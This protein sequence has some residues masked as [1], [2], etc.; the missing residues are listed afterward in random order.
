[1]EEEI[2]LEEEVIEEQPPR[3]VG[4][5]YLKFRDQEHYEKACEEAGF[6]QE[7]PTEWKT[8]KK[9]IASEDP[10]GNWV[11][12]EWEEREPIAWEKVII[13]NTFD[14]TIGDIGTIWEEGEWSFNEETGEV[15]Q[16]TSPLELPGYHVNFTGPLPL[17][18]EEAIIEIPNKPHRKISTLHH[19]NDIVEEIVPD[20]LQEPSGDVLEEEV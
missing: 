4:S 16:I 14:Y 11:E 9:T 7:N 8:I 20:A 3:P 6:V 17:S 1:M 13:K 19:P 10:E 15:E 2:L 5:Y 18:F 12:E